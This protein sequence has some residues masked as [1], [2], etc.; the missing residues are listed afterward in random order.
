MN[1]N[2]SRKG[3]RQYIPN[4]NDPRIQKR[5]TK[6]LGWAAGCVRSEPREMAKNWID[7]H[8]GQQQNELGRWLR[9]KL[10]VCR[11]NT[12]F[13]GD[14]GSKCKEYSLNQAGWNEVS[15]ML[16]GIQ[17]ANAAA[18]MQAEGKG[19]A[20]HDMELVHAWVRED[21]KDELASKD[22]QYT[23]KNS[24]RLWHPLQNLTRDAK[25]F[26]WQREGLGFN[27]DIQACAPTLIVQHAQHLGLDEWLYGIQEFLADPRAFRKHVADVAGYDYNDEQQAKKVK[28][29][30]TALFCGA[31]L[32]A[33]KDFALFHLLD[34]DYKR[35]KA[36]QND[37][38][39]ML[40]KDDIKRCWQVIEVESMGVIKNEGGRKIALNSK[41]KWNRYF[42]LERLVLNSVRGY[43]TKQGLKFFL[44]HDGAL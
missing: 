43:L 23:E 36:L 41:R 30:V 29:L 34:Q 6:A 42:D 13:F 4:F 37:A 24:A 18:P 22:F 21:Y 38:R 10:L 20:K 9:D 39:L 25:L 27:Y 3:T 19:K 31:K 2:K 33:N 1:N 7:A 40:L 28:A 5:V 17:N 8:L 26:V 12:Y 35:V 16:L 14:D 11:D 32:G 15:G 44:E